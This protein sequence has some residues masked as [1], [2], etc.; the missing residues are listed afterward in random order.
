M[1]TDRLGEIGIGIGEG[2]L[3]CEPAEPEPHQVV[4]LERGDAMAEFNE[5]KVA[6]GGIERDLA[7]LKQV[8]QELGGAVFDAARLREKADQLGCEISQAGVK[9]KQR[10]QAM[11]GQ[12]KAA[13]EEDAQVAHQATYKMRRNMHMTA[14]AKLV[15]V[16][17]QFQDEQA[18]FKAAQQKTARRQLKLVNPDATE[19]ELQQVAEGNGQ[20]I[21]AQ[22]LA[23]QAHAR[24]EAALADVR[25]KHDEIVKLEK[26]IGELHGLIVEVALL[27]EAQGEQLDDIESQVAN[28]KDY[29][30]VAVDELRVANEYAKSSRKRTAQL[31][32]IGAG[33]GLAVLFPVAAPVLGSAQTA[34]TA[35]VLALVGSGVGAG[36]VKG[37]QGSVAA[38]QQQAEAAAGTK[39]I[40]V[41]CPIA[42][43]AHEQKIEVPVSVNLHGRSWSCVECGQPFELRTCA[44]C[45]KLGTA[46]LAS[47]SVVASTELQNG[48]LPADGE[49][50]RRTCQRKGG[51]CGGEMIGEDVI[52]HPPTS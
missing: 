7:D 8:Y 13:L 6:I 21:F 26:D 42:E 38:R 48:L 40:K 20:Q 37:A 22:M 16:M 28:A 23:S 12:L 24:Q 3:V 11:D 27:V 19:Q 32:M 14:A 45:F 2:G 29:M 50:E 33:V 52:V 35:G 30:T 25:A 18:A 41:K 15:L 44:K 10:L 17:G 9:V 5:I 49:A 34:G 1:A 46:P 43:C 47:S 31:A 39:K 36:A 4:D 51:A